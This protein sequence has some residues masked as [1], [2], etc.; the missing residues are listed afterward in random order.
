MSIEQY[1]FIKKSLVP[2]W[3]D[4]QKAINKLGLP[5][6]IDPEL[7]PN[8]DSGFLP[9]KLKNVKTG[10]E[11]DYGNSD[12]LLK[13]YPKIKNRVAPRDWCITLRWGSDM[14]ECACALAAS[15]ALMADFDAVIYYPDG[16]LVFSLEELKTQ[17]NE[18]LKIVGNPET[19]DPSQVLTPEIRSRLEELK[20][21]IAPRR[22]SKPFLKILMMLLIIFSF[23]L[24]ANL[25]TVLITGSSVYWNS[26]HWPLVL[27]LFFSAI[28]VLLVKRNQGK[29]SGF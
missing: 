5:I 29:K 6:E 17:M 16:D 10:F 24:I 19:Y 11:I 25:A 1:A 18:T 28:T 3:N 22:K 9:C 23:S 8:E 26:H 7:K 2:S 15:T 13:L 12:K 21:E 27:S 14:R 4:W 20:R